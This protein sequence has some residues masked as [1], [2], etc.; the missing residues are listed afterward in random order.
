MQIVIRRVKIATI[1]KIELKVEVESKEDRRKYGVTM[2]MRLMEA[3]N[4]NDE[5][6]YAAVVKS[7]CTDGITHS[8]SRMSSDAKVKY[9]PGVGTT[10]RAGIQPWTND[11]GI[12]KCVKDNEV[13]TLSTIAQ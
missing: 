9:K 4:D 6:G 1:L 13:V 2:E 10:A 5:E 3:D 12:K 11:P 7:S 8:P